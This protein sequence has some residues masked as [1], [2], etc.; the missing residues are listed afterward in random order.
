[1]LQQRSIAVESATN[2]REALAFLREHVYAVVLLDLMMPDIDG[3]GVLD[4]M[5]ADEVQSPPVVLVVT[6]AERHVVERL[7]AQ[8]IHGIIRKPFDPLEL[9]EL[10]TACVELKTRGRF[11][12]MALAVISGA[13]LIALLQRLH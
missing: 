12:A 2:G 11:E 3:F 1:M 13:P 9:T 4:A 10:V 8:R 6:G 7:D 5:K